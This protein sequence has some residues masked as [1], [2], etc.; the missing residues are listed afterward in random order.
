MPV[1]NDTVILPASMLKV[2]GRTGSSGSLD[3]IRSGLFTLHHI[4]PYNYAY[5][6]G[7]VIDTLEKFTG[8]DSELLQKVARIKNKIFYIST[9]SPE[10]EKK[11]AWMGFNLFEGPAGNFRLD[12]PGHA[13]ETVRPISFKEDL[14]NKIH[15]LKSLLDDYVEEKKVAVGYELTTKEWALRD[16]KRLLN[17]LE[18][19]ATHG[20]SRHSFFPSD[21]LVIYSENAAWQKKMGSGVGGDTLKTQF[22]SHMIASKSEIHVAQIGLFQTQR[23]A[24]DG[25][26]CE[27]VFWRLRKPEEPLPQAVFNGTARLQPPQGV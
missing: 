13:P 1:Q 17:H 8:V 3:K 2:A 11:F 12:D 25:I 24:A 18:K 10:Q 21:W 4:I 16:C 14:W 9:G 27:T 5:F 20:N 6:V 15:E 7:H 19:M 23:D 26:A 22:Q